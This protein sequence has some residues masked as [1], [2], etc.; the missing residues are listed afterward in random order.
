MAESR[1]VKCISSIGSQRGKTIQDRF[2][3][4]STEIVL[5]KFVCA[6]Q[7][8]QGSLCQGCLYVFPHYVAFTCDLPGYKY[9]VLLKLSEISRVKK[10]KT[11]FIVPNAINICMIGGTSH[12]FASF[13]S[14]NEAYHQIYDLW[15]IAKGIEAA[16]A[17]RSLDKDASF[18]TQTYDAR[19][20][21]AGPKTEFR[22]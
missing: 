5:G 20:L 11:L 4:P 14:R 8:K 16:R 19:T 10:A 6:L 22:S 12:F 3:L 21:P 13:L 18:T 15:L 2:G 7:R 1:F 9:S 17:D